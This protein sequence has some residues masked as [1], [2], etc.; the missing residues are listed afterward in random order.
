MF[1]KYNLPD[2]YSLLVAISIENG[3]ELNEKQ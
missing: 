2:I 1:I 3:E